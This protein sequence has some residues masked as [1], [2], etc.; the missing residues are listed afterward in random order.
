V[1]ALTRKRFEVAKYLPG[2]SSLQVCVGRIVKQE[3]DPALRDAMVR[4]AVQR[5]TSAQIRQVLRG[6]GVQVGG[7]GVLSRRTVE[8]FFGLGEEM[9]HAGDEEK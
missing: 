9:G 8:E 6:A 4:E 5:V 3:S 7:R 1:H 2:R